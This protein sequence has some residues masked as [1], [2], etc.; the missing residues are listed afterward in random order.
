MEFPRASCSSYSPLSLSLPLPPRGGDMWRARAC[1][2]VC[3]GGGS[4]CPT[5]AWRV[6]DA[7]LTRACLVCLDATASITL[8]IED[9][10]EE[11]KSQAQELNDDGIGNPIGTTASGG[12]SAPSSACT[13]LAKLEDGVLQRLGVNTFEVGQARA[14]PNTSHSAWRNEISTGRSRRLRLFL[15]LRRI[16]QRA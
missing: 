5:R 4:L 12:G 6:P 14:L 16:P 7:C 3:G 13:W 15:A 10:I 11:L 8:T 9:L 2:C 1:V